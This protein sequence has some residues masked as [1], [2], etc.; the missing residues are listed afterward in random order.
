MVV[1][2][3]QDVQRGQ[4]LVKIPKDIGKTRD[5]EKWIV[6]V[7]ENMLHMGGEARLEVRIGLSFTARNNRPFDV[8]QP[9]D[10]LPHRVGELKYMF[11]P[12]QAAS[13]HKTFRTD[14]ELTEWTEK[15]ST[16]EPTNPRDMAFLEFQYGESFRNS[17]FSFDS[18]VMI[19]MW[20]TK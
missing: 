14:A 7:L 2:D 9:D 12:M 6:D 4:T 16:S 19:S 18:P 3:R 20:I 11:C 10:H 13:I 1:N 15:L 8:A 5:I 17:G